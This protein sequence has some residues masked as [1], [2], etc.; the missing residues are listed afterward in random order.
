MQTAIV[1]FRDAGPDAEID[2]L[3]CQIIG[4]GY[5]CRP[6][7]SVAEVLAMIES[8]PIDLLIVACRHWQWQALAAV[9]EAADSYLPIVLISESI[10]DNLLERCASVD[11]DTVLC[12][13]VNFGLLLFKIRSSLR[14]SELYRRERE[15]K[16]RLLDYWQMSDLEQEV[17]AKL[18]NSVL[19]ADFLETDAVSVSMSPMA[20]FNGDLVLVAKTPEN[21]LHLLL[22]DFTGHGLAASIAATPLA[23]IFYGMTRKGFDISEIVVEVNTKLHRMLPANRFLAATLVALYPEDSMLKTITCGL[24]DH[25]L[26]NGVDKSYR[27]ITSSNIPLGI[28]AAIEPDA[29][30]HRVGEHDSL[31]L[32]TDG[33]FEAE[34]ARGEL[35][36]AER[37]L[38]AILESRDS[39]FD[40]LQRRLAEHTGGAVRKDDN[41]MVVL[42]CAVDSVPWGGSQVQAAGHKLAA[43]TWKQMMEF[44]ID[45]LRCTNPVPVIVNTLTE[46]QGLQGHR[47]AI[48][49]IVTELFANALDHGVLQLDSAEKNT[50]EGFLRFYELKQQ[51]LQT[52]SA[53]KIRLFFSH[54]PTDVGGRLI[55]KVADSGSGFD[56]RRHRTD[57]EHNSG[58]SGRGIALLEQLCSSVTY[59]GRGNRVTVAF[60]WQA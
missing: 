42:R 25:Y 49:L 11:I 37:V 22:G 9:R 57:L 59:H 56:W 41:T 24:P 7:T 21:H 3:E 30:L 12:R 50:P 4:Q 46:L 10:N 54:H 6:A 36:G 18:F 45:S 60:D 14:L 58:Y 31:Y 16:N 19:K 48:F 52:L 34:N 35:F 13:P 15:Q 39:D 47:Q 20:L 44:D 32:L 40:I 27:A 2:H 5:I 17:A 23:D 29:Q 55:V 28:Q 1:F 8:Q 53:G 38:Q 51:R 33:V 26:V 43:M